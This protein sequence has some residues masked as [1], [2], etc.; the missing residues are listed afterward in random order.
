MCTHTMWGKLVNLLV[1]CLEGVKYITML[2]RETIKI[3]IKCYELL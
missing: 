1:R 3:S 2:T